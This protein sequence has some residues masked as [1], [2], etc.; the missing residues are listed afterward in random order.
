MENVFICF[1]GTEFS[2]KKLSFFHKSFLMF[3]LL[4]RVFYYLKL[5][6]GK[7]QIIL[8]LNS[9]KIFTKKISNKFNIM[10]RIR[11]LWLITALILLVN[12]IVYMTIRNNLLLYFSDFLP[13]LCSL[14]AAYGTYR[15]FRGFKSYDFVKIAWLL[16][17]LG[18]FLDFIAE[19]VYGILEVGFS[20]DMNN[21]FP[22]IADIFWCSSYIAYFIG[23]I[24][25]FNGYRKSGFPLGN[26]KMFALL[27]LLF[28]ILCVTIIYFLLIPIIQD[29]ETKI[30]TKVVSL[31]YPIGDILTV[32]MA[33]ILLYFISQFGKGLITMPWKMLALGFF[34]FSVSDLLYSYL[35]WKDLYGSGNLIDMGWHLGYLLIGIA[36]FYQRELVD[37]VK[38][39][40]AL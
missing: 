15:A 36:G 13:I 16:L 3:Q 10:K 33:V 21:T 9:F 39:R 17:L 20:V 7:M 1:L 11:L 6:S 38:E 31:Y 35:G 14:I 5:H 22:S 40:S 30:L 29:E 24:M 25:L 27:S 19:S 26:M 23:L 18:V 37:S 12:F 4:T 2:G 8:N 32:S 28:T 34:C